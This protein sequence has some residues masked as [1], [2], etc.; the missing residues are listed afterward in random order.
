MLYL[1][2][3]LL[4]PDAGG[5]AA[6][7]GGSHDLQRRHL[8]AQVHEEGHGKR[9]RDHRIL[10]VDWL[11][12]IYSLKYWGGRSKLINRCGCLETD[13]LI[14]WLTDRLINWLPLG[15][16]HD[17]QRRHLAA[18]VHEEGHGKRLN[19]SCWLIDWLVTQFV[20]SPTEGVDPNWSI[21]W[22]RVPRDW[23]V[24]W[25]IDWLAAQVHE[26]G[27]G[28]RGR[29]H[30]ILVGW[31]IDWLVVKKLAKG[32]L[33]PK[34]EVPW[35]S[36]PG[37][38][39]NPGL[40]CERRALQKRATLGGSHPLIDWWTVWGCLKTDWLID[41]WCSRLGC[42]RSCC[43]PP[44]GS[45]LRRTWPRGTTLPASPSRPGRGTI[46]FRWD[47]GP[48]DGIRIFFLFFKFFFFSFKAYPVIPL[49]DWSNLAGR[50][51]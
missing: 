2:Q 26:E 45:S 16:S 34:L 27:H 51:L 24:D 1:F 42:G 37:R 11:I 7:L 43:W 23:L 31:W 28:K 50:Y 33:H 19:S 47:E 18:Q 29:D 14:D 8:A 41:W 21:D 48:N 9:G 13:W 3:I 5:A 4:P 44:L 32:N 20:Y 15:G 38:E 22:L 40:H 46:S 49:A 10:V 35:L 36:S 39:L 30:W 17:L 6:P 25:L 12:G